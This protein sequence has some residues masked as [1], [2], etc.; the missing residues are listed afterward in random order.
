MAAKK[1]NVT[2]WLIK[3]AELDRIR[4]SSLRNLVGL[5]FDII[6]TQA[7]AMCLNG[8]SEIIASLGIEED[9]SIVATNR[10][11]S[12]G[13]VPVEKIGALQRDAAEFVKNTPVTVDVW[14]AVAGDFFAAAVRRATTGIHT[15]FAELARK[16]GNHFSLLVINN[17]RLPLL[18]LLA[19]P[20]HKGLKIPAEGE[21]VQLRFEGTV[22]GKRI[23]ARLVY[24]SIEA[25]E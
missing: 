23:N 2:I 16:P 3:A 6:Y 1:I 13:L 18:E 19:A 20:L 22:D 21:V 5:G 7:Y 25:V 14:Q 4:T 15:M 24:A 12:A 8:V 17:D 9:Q 11:S 10:F